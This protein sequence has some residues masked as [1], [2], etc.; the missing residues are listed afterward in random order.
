MPGDNTD[1]SAADA[2]RD[3]EEE[4][5][6]EEAEPEKEE[7]TPEP[8]PEP[9]ATADEGEPEEGDGE[10]ALPQ[11]DAKIREAIGD[12]AEAL[13]AWKRQWKGV[14]KRENRLKAE[15][16]R[17]D[18]FSRYEQALVNPDTAEAALRHLVQS[19]AEATGIKLTISASDNAAEGEDWEK[20]GYYSQK[21]Y[22]LAKELEAQKAKLNSIESERAQE[23]QERE[24]RGWL[25]NMTPKVAKQIAAEYDGFEVTNAM[26]KE[27]VTNLPQF[28]S[29][30]AKAV[31]MYYADDL[32]KHTAGKVAAR[33]KKLPEL[34]D[35]SSS[36][37]F[38]VP[39]NPEHYNAVHAYAEISR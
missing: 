27:A 13:E 31:K 38:E 25:N 19:V 15:E 9:D 11:L 10:D 30:P 29:E 28:K 3:I 32:I 4:T 26:L 6:T 16:E 5:A 36:K 2:L 7:A 20:A 33:H 17:L 14:E 34:P 35:T 39:T 22:E 37:G 12:N 21:E 8:E 1:Y 18:V 23:R 24:E